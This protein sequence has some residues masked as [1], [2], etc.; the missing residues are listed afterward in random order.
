MVAT[1]EL[2]LDEIR[3]SLS[4]RKQLDG[5]ALLAGLQARRGGSAALDQ[6]LARWR[7]AVARSRGWARSLPPPP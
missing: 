4:W 5:R 3:R 7:E 6:Q 2:T 1:A